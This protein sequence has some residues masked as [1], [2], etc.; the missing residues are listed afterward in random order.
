MAGW[1]HLAPTACAFASNLMLAAVRPEWGFG[2]WGDVAGAHQAERGACV[3]AREGTGCVTLPPFLPQV[4][5]AAP[6]KAA[7][8]RILGPPM[9]PS[10]LLLGAGNLQRAAARQVAA[11]AT[12]VLLLQV[13]GSKRAG[14]RAVT[15]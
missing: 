12:A 14:C 11:A 1:R 10:L 4:Y 2:V 15:R 8:C 13:G 5:V 7:S 9:L 3:S 6:R